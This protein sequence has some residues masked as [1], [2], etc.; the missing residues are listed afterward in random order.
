M[1]VIIHTIKK[2]TNNI[3]IEGKATV[4][5]KINSFKQTKK[6]EH[7]NIPYNNISYILI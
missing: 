1:R 7:L 3:T 6:N 5:R 2:T 4:I